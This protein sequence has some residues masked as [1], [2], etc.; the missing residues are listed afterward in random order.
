MNVKTYPAFHSHRLI[1]L[2][3]QQ[4]A[5]ISETFSAAAAAAMVLVAAAVR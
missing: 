4:V 1:E 3:W 2:F 5:P